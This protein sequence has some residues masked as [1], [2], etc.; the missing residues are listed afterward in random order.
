MPESA[1]RDGGTTSAKRQWETTTKSAVGVGEATSEVAVVGEPKFGYG[2]SACHEAFANE[3][4][5][6]LPKTYVE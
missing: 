1:R 3:N 6:E 5:Q 4:P 2:V